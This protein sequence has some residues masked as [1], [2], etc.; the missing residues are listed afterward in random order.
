MAKTLEITYEEIPFTWRCKLLF[1][2]HNNAWRPIFQ[3]TIKGGYLHTILENSSWRKWVATIVKS[4]I[5]SM[6]DANETAVA[7]LI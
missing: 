6:P 5:L 1:F 3:I 4:S 2:D 7:I